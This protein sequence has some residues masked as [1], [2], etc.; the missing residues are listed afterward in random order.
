MKFY[1]LKATKNVVVLTCFPVMI[2]IKKKCFPFTT[3]QMMSLG[4]ET[5]NVSP[6]GSTYKYI[7]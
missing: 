3:N 4:F 7:K 2:D 6:S 5:T 1:F